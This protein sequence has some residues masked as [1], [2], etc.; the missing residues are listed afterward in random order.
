MAALQYAAAAEADADPEL[1][2]RAADVS[3]ESLQPSL[4]AFI[5]SRWLDV[6]PTS[7]EAHRAAA[8]AALALDDTDRSAADYR[9][10]LLSSPRGFDAELAAL[11]EELTTTDN[12]YGARRLADRL[13][14]YFPAVP[15]LLRLQAYAALRADDP[16]AAVH[17]FTAFLAAQAAAPPSAMPSSTP[18]TPSLTASSPSASA[19]PHEVTQAL[20]RAQVLSGDTAGPLAEA[21]A[22]LLQAPTVTHRWDY[23]VLLLA[24]QQNGA[25]R[26]QL[27][28]LRKSPEIAAPAL[29][30]LGLLDLQEGRP[31]EAAVHFAELVTTGKYLGD[32]LYHLGTIAEQHGDTERALRLYAEVQS[33]DEAVPAMF[34]A[35]A[36][37]RAHG[38]AHVAEELLDRLVEEE[39]ARAPEILAARIR[40]YAEAGDLPLAAATVDRGLLQYPDSVELRYAAATLHEQQGNL[41]LALRELAAVVKARPRDPAALNAYAFT[42]ADHGRRLRVAYKLIAQ[43]HAAAPKSAAILDSVGWVL[44]RQGHA[45]QALP[46]LNEAFADDKGG[47]IAAHLGEVLWHLGRPAEADRAWA[48]GVVADADNVL[49]KTTRARLHASD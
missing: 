47:D 31:T 14:G 20:W 42:L 44:Y 17:G 4:T 32:A 40:L 29:R 26:S 16:A 45:E 41:R 24:A 9:V 30:L 22:A 49:L 12:A 37:L 28:V 46:Y 3:A 10:I 1:L 25:A 19:D 27:D 36:I 18:P 34:R 43:A 6:V 5:A 7:V 8:G 39:A 2:Q 38:A 33:G 35:A 23:A 48:A 13:A 15:A 21:N 11:E